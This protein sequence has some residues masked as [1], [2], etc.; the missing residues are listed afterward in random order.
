M[1]LLDEPTA[2]LDLE[3]Q[4]AI[5]SILRERTRNGGLAV[6]IVT[7]DVNLA[8]RYC[9]RVLLLSDGKVVA[10]GSPREVVTPRVLE[11][12]YGVRLAQLRLPGGEGEWIVPCDGEAALHT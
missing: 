3:H 7:H 4:L 11:P 1:L 5:F 12:V 6:V 9:D 2:S 10:C 8:A